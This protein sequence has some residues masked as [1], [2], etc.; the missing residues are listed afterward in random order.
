LDELPLGLAQIGRQA[1]HHYP[2]LALHRQLGIVSARA[3]AAGAGRWDPFPI[4]ADAVERT[5]F[6]IER[7]QLAASLVE[8]SQDVGR[9]CLI[10]G[11]HIGDVLHRRDQPVDLG[12][13]GLGGFTVLNRPDARDVILVRR[14][15]RFVLVGELAGTLPSSDQPAIG[16]IVGLIDHVPHLVD[17]LTVPVGEATR[18]TATRFVVTHS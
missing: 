11:S 13:I 4:R 8:R 18:A 2:S 10:V 6:L 3:L 14:E 1:G 12:D 17:G 15:P 9:S 7:L 5:M 16:G